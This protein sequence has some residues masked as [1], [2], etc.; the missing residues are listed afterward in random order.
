MKEIL[1][2]SIPVPGKL[3]RVVP[4]E[5]YN[6]EQWHI[7]GGVRLDCTTYPGFVFLLIILF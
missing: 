7:P 1:R 5:G 6:I 2:M 3:P 4:L